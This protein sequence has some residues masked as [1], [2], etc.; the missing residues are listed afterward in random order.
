MAMT[1]IEKLEAKYSSLIKQFKPV[2]AAVVRNQIKKLQ[3]EHVPLKS[4]LPDMSAE[5]RKEALRLMHKTFILSDLLESA[6]MDFES[7][8][9]KFGNLSLV[10]TK[11]IKEISSKA[12]KLVSNIDA[13]NDSSLSENFGNMADEC[14]LV[15]S[16]IIFKYQAKK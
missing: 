7:Y 10:I 9:N 13:M 5:E 1:E 11:D 16:N 3:V 12:H 2:Q 6:A 4:L 8:L 15:V 14:D